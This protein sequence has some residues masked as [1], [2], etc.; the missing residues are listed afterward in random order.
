MLASIAIDVSICFLFVIPLSI[1][2][3]LVHIGRRESPNGVEG[4]WACLSR[5]PSQFT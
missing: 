2:M 3:V 1:L 4:R 5:P